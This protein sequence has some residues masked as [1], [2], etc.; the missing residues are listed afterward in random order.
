[1]KS[2]L[3]I[4]L[5]AGAV[6]F[7]YAASNPSIWG[8]FFYPLQYR[9][10]IKK[11]AAKND[12]DPNFVAAVIYEES[13]F[14]AGQQSRAGAIGLMQLLPATAESIA[15]DLNEPDFTPDI[16][17]EPERNIRYGTHYF[18]YLLNRFGDE[19]LALAAYNAGET[20]V[21]QW[22]KEGR[23]EI[24]FEETRKF[25]TRVKESKDMYETIYGKWYEE[26]Q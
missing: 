24:P 4:F 5:V 17:L 10:A 19:E 15:R 18:R 2:S 11:N 22:R 21:D 26:S 16:L 3:F 20:N 8:P 12:L 1:M 6:L 25:V 13:K 9:E 7:V 14:Y 23:E